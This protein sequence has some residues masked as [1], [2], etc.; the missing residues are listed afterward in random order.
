MCIRDR[1][2]GKASNAGSVENGQLVIVSA[3]RESFSVSRLPENRAPGAFDLNKLTLGNLTVSSG[4]RI[5]EQTRGS[6]VTAISRSDLGMETI[7]VGNIVSYHVNSANMVDYIVLT[8]VTGSAYIYGMMVGGYKTVTTTNLYGSS[9]SERYVWNLR[10][11]TQ[12]IEFDPSVT[13]HGSS[14]D[15]VG[16]VVGKNRDGKNTIQEVKPL[17]ILRNVKLS[18]FFESQGEPYVTV[19]GQTYRIADNVECYYNRTG[20]KVSKD[21]WLTGD[22]RLV[23]IKTYSD[24]FTLY[25]DSVGRQVRVIAAN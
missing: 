3:D 25:V 16:V 9:T 20:N 4:V 21:N 10:S 13:Y 11:G 24:S 23:S 17:T 5:Y 19:N 22:N 14:G 7:P 1:S 8:N 18:D 2:L 6:N 12:E 15:M